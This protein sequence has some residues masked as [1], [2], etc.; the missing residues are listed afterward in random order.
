M[1]ADKVILR[2]KQGEA[3]AINMRVLA[4]GEAFDL[5]DCT[6]TVQVKNA[7]YINIEPL[8]EKQITTT[9]D[10]NTVGQITNAGNGQFQVMFT[11]E[12][13]DLPVNEYYL[14]IFLNNGVTKDII[15]SNCCCSGKYIICQQ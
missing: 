10:V 12:D 5:S 14:V 7:P 9:S 4:G 1:A 15:S 8:F 11:E 2:L 13:T 6:L 3:L